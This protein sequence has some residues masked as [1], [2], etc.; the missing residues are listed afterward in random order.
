MSCSICGRGS[1]TRSFH[2]LAE[3]EQWDELEG[4]DERW[5]ISELIDAR[6]RI[7]DLLREV[8][9]LTADEGHEK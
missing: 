5:L 8:E 2:S 4:R 1:C 6:N 7:D 9:Q 3:Q